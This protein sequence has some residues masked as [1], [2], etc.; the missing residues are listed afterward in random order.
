MFCEGEKGERRQKRD[1]QERGSVDV[2]E[3]EKVMREK[4]G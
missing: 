4:L 1:S 3:K 2:R